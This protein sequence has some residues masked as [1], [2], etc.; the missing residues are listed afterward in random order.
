MKFRGV[1]SATIDASSPL[2]RVSA[3]DAD[4]EDGEEDSDDD[5]GGGDGGGE[6]DDDGWIVSPRLGVFFRR[7]RERLRLRRERAGDD[8]P[9]IFRSLG[10]LKTG[11]LTTVADTRRPERSPPLPLAGGGGIGVGTLLTAQQRNSLHRTSPPSGCTVAGEDDDEDGFC[12]AA[13]E[14]GATGLRGW[15]WAGAFGGWR[16]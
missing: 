8:G 14:D 6:C 15:V 3:S 4:E 1:T 12:V 16:W 2:T 11:L 9:M 7:P 13:A 5:E 10:L